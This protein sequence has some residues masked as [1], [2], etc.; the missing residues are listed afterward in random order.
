MVDIEELLRMRC[1]EHRGAGSPKFWWVSRDGAVVTVRFGRVGTAGQTRVKEFADE[2]AAIAHVEGLVSEKVKKGY[3]EMA[4]GAA[5]APDAAAAVSGPVVW[6]PPVPD[7]RAGGPAVS[8]SGAAEGPV[9]LPDENVLVLPAEWRRKVQRRRGG[10]VE[11]SL[12][13]LAGAVAKAEAVMK[14]KSTERAEVLA[15]P[16]S[17]GELV[18]AAEG[19]LDGS[20]VTPL[21]AAAAVVA[22]THACEHRDFVQLAALADGWIAAHGL[23]FATR[24]VAEAAGLDVRGQR[25]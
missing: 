15:A 1:F 13:R 10:R 16:R 7:G 22:S 8:D 4:A 23:T 2:A 20:R 6:D 18:A 5:A 3:M 9:V 12:P 24:G 19:F 17:D 14:A 21:G 25:Y 11:G